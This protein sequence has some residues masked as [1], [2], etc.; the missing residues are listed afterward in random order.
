MK[1]APFPR[2]L[3]AANGF[4]RKTLAAYRAAQVRFGSRRNVT[5]IT[6]SIK[7]R[8]GRLAPEA[9]PV[10]AIHVRKKRHRGLRR[11]EK[12]PARI[13]GVATDVIEA[14]YAPANQNLTGIPTAVALPLRPGASI[15]R[16]KGGSAGTLGGIVR[17]AAGVRYLLGAAHVL[18]EGAGYK[19]GDAI[20]H[21]GPADAP[22]LPQT[23][24]SV[25][26]AEKLHQGSDQGIAKLVPQDLAARNVA[27]G[28]D[29]RILP[30]AGALVAP[31][32]G[33][34][35][36][37]SGRTTKDTFAVVQGFGEILGVRNAIQLRKRDADPGPAF[38][39]GDSGAV[40]F[41]ANTRAAVGLH[42]R[43]SASGS[44]G[45]ATL[46]GYLLDRWALQWE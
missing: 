32:Q 3:A 25:A 21:P 34:E 7:E 43:A 30:P 26:M 19:R 33:D 45:V 22:A 15:G 8:R 29:I 20:L 36:R 40:W 31:R 10:I 38:A 14:E 27:L 18:S 9:G 39:P 41:D 23:P 1:P 12:I 44:Y 24:L 42:I 13:R 35:L 4:D 6:I 2:W 11:W 16:A 46:V 17:D 28:S 5:G 37:K